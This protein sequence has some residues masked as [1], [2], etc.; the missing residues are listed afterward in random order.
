MKTKMILFSLILTG[1][2]SA[3]DLISFPDE[4]LTIADPAGVPNHPASA[5]YLNGISMT[6][7]HHPIISGLNL[8]S[9][10]ASG[11]MVLVPTTSWLTT[12]VAWDR[13][14]VTSFD[15]DLKSGNRFHLITAGNFGKRFIWGID[16]L[17]GFDKWTVTNLE[18]DQTEAVINHQNWSV[19]GNLMVLLSENHLAGITVNNGAVS[20]RERFRKEVLAEY[21]FLQPV[22]QGFAGMIWREGVFS[23][24]DEIGYQGGVWV[25]VFDQVRLSGSSQYFPETGFRY[26]AG[27]SVN[28]DLPTTRST[29]RYQGTSAKADIG[30]FG[31]F[32]A[33]DLK[34][35]T[36]PFNARQLNPLDLVRDHIQPMSSARLLSAP[37]IFTSLSGEDSLRVRFSGSDQGTGIRSAVIHIYSTETGF[38]VMEIKK[39]YPQLKQVNELFNWDGLNKEGILVP[40][41][42]YQTQAVFT[43]Q[44]GLTSL[45]DLLDFKVLSPLND[46]TAPTV[47]F[48]WNETTVK[49]KPEETHAELSG[50]F[51]A[52]D[53]E[54]GKLRWYVECIR[55]MSDSVQIPLWK[56]SGHVP[57]SRTRLVVP[58]YRKIYQQAFEG[59]Y[60]MK[61]TA[62]DEVGNLTATYSSP[63]QLLQASMPEKA[64][65]ALVEAKT[66]ITQPI[67]QLPTI[68]IL[69]DPAAHSKLK[70]ELDFNNQKISLT[71]LVLRSDGIL[72]ISLSQSTLNLIGVLLQDNPDHKL[73]AIIPQSAKNADFDKLFDYFEQSFSVSSSRIQIRT[74]GDSQKVI[75]QVK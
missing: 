66:P 46:R 7:F 31:Q 64:I 16:A 55:V 2:L 44:A 70:A 52:T 47:S 69:A 56:T 12:G 58:L 30:S 67:L 54:Q 72:D 65:Q 32:V 21:A 73:T 8:G 34:S 57:T 41:G 74:A 10:A 14:A 45:T 5:H 63:V 25:D 39:L 40:N 71:S 29:F 15:K 19:S 22:W 35:K 59:T 13:L 9:A 49:L 3:Q 33:I 68:K 26:T 37:V 43:D 50:L 53:N 36:D 18:T 1:S 28:L 17:S 60:L 11:A 61:M 75:F 27:I 51:S 48:E 4:G 42:D 62:V 23:G 38:Q 6:F 24:S 20:H